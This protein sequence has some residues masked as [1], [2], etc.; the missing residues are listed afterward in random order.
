MVDIDLEMLVVDIAVVAGRRRTDRGLRVVEDMKVG[1]KF[2]EVGSKK[3]KRDL[4]RQMF[5]NRKD[6][7]IAVHRN[8]R[9]RPL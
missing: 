9:N 7:A 8:L 5:E 3:W 4:G 6:L 2:A 1:R